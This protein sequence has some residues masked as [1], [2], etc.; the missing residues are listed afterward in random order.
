MDSQKR[1]PSA[2]ELRELSKAEVI[3]QIVEAGQPGNSALAEI[4]RRSA[5]K[6][7]DAV[8]D[9][10][11]ASERQA[12]WMRRLTVA[13]LAVALA[14]VV[15]TVGSCLSAGSGAQGAPPAVETEGG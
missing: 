1:Y 11:R 10:D 2:A 6:I 9:F 14:Q 5:K 7:V 13:I 8:K 3:D 4:Q 12:K 15:A